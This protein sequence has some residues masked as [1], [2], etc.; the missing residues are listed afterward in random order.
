MND[1]I[2]G[3][4]KVCVETE[5]QWTK[6]S[7]NLLKKNTHKNTRLHKQPQY[8]KLLKLIFWTI[9]QN[10]KENHSQFNFWK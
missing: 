9:F 6:N 3:N 1:F 8:I 7:P 10:K 2:C 5:K 4:P